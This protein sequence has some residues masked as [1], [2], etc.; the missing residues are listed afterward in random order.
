[1]PALRRAS[2]TSLLTLL[3]LIAGGGG[4]A[5]GPGR[6]LPPGP[7]GDGAPPAA[8][9]AGLA[10]RREVHVATDGDDERG[11][12]SRKRPFANLARAAKA[13]GPG[14]AIRLHPGEYPGGIW[15]QDLSGRAD[16]PVW[17]GG[18]PGA[19]R[20]R[21]VG[22]TEGLHL[23]RPQYLVLH[24]LEVVGARVNGVN[25]DDGGD[26]ATPERAHDVVLRNLEIR[27]VGTGGNHDG[28]K[29]SGIWRYRVEDCSLRRVDAGSGIDQVGCHQGLILACRFDQMGANAVQ[30]KGGSRDVE[31]TRCTFD[32]A[33][34]RGVNIGGSTGPAFFR[35]PLSTREPNAEARDVRVTAC[36][37]GECTTPFAFVGAIDCLVANNTLRG[38]TWRWLFRVLQETTSTPDHAFLETQGCRVA[39]NVFVFRAGALAAH[40]NVGPHTRGDT[41]VIDHNLWFATDDPARSAPQGLPVAETAGRHGIDPFPAAALAP[42]IGAASPAAGAGTPIAGL[43]A[44]HDGRSFATPPS[45]GAFEAR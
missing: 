4:A 8:L 37:F 9:D 15:I 45:A 44:D 27:D 11:D 35:P 39:N 28:L 22:G 38:T 42:R 40:V 32:R 33:G 30:V 18:L 2:L 17:L 31:I 3:A 6:P 20:P 10:P 12:G 34:A 19:A 1:M 23:V 5:A 43:H 25:V 7:G 21:I 26:V 13:A 24:D 41:F 16:A 36:L 14:T 29:L